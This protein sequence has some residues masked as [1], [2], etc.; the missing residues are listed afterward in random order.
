MGLEINLQNREYFRFFDVLYDDKKNGVVIVNNDSHEIKIYIKG[1]ILLVT[2]GPDSDMALLKAVAA[3]NGLTDSEF[4]E[5]IKIREDAPD[6]LGELLIE[7]HLVSY[8]FWNKFLFL[9]AKYHL[10]VMFRM[11]NARFTFEEIEPDIPRHN[12]LNSNLKELLIETIRNIKDD[13]FIKKIISGPLARF[14]K[15][16]IQEDNDTYNFLND[17]EKR[18]FSAIDGEKTAKEIS[19]YV[20][21]DYPQVRNILSLFL[22][23]GLVSSAQGTVKPEENL[24]YEE[25]INVYLDI[26]KILESNFNRE[27][28]KE[29]VAVLKQC[30]KELTDQNVFLF[31]GIDLCNA[32]SKEISDEI[33][34]RFLELIKN[35]ASYLALC[36]SF[37][38]LIYLLLMR[39]KKV[40]GTSI[41]EKTINE[42]LNMINYIKKY[43]RDK[44][45]MR[46]IEGNLQDYLTQFKS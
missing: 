23:L 25:I 31:Q 11:Q 35:G 14:E 7:K 28:G 44:F 43:R 4:N 33:Y 5:L 16:M 24:K 9:K 45:I 41:T 40:L 18:I 21:L 13:L 34:F 26:F 6:S 19:L 2:E 3:K 22:F 10:E 27:V 20:G 17:T 8:H 1:R 37:N 30:V 32:P 36:T 12:S 38:K 42:M 46:Y 39:M 15:K 29:F